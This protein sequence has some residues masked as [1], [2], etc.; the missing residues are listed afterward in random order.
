M[1]NGSCPA[2]HFLYNTSSQEVTFHWMI[3]DAAKSGQDKID[4]DL[5]YIRFRILKCKLHH[6]SSSLALSCLYLR[7]FNNVYILEH[8][9][10]HRIICIQLYLFKYPTRM[11]SFCTA[12]CIFVLMLFPLLIYIIIMCQVA[13]SMTD[14]CFDVVGISKEKKDPKSVKNNR[15]TT[16]Y[17]NPF[18]FH[19]EENKLLKLIVGIA[20]IITVCSWYYK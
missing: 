5:W 7:P 1:N 8:W 14:L 4:W 17:R 19:L 12:S 16:T 6:C 15:G 13:A 10:L 3:L 18:A 9:K 11:R 2:L 20:K